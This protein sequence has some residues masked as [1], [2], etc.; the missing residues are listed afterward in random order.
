MYDLQSPPPALPKHC[1]VA[2]FQATASSSDST[3]PETSILQRLFPNVVFVEDWR[4]QS[5]KETEIEDEAEDELLKNIVLPTALDH[6]NF[7]LGESLGTYWFRSE[8]ERIV[9]L[10]R[11]RPR[12]Q[13]DNDQSELAQNFETKIGSRRIRM[14]LG[15]HEDEQ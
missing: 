14:E 2:T 4:K 13:Q 7:K 15:Q 3:A 10:A 1:C 5:T 8:R 12:P 9:K 6:I 11:K